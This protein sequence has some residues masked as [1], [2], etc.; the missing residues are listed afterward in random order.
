MALSAVE[1]PE[2]R[3]PERQLATLEDFLTRMNLAPRAGV[4]ASR[5]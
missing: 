2:I 5:A 3:T 4:G 1:H